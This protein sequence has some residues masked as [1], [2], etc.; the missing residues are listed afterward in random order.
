MLKEDKKDDKEVILSSMDVEALYPNINIEITAKEVGKE[1][2]ETML[3]YQNVDYRMAGILIASNMSQEGL[4]KEKLSEIV[5]RRKSNQGVRPGA[6]TE[7]LKRKRRYD[8]E[9]EEVE[10]SKWRM[11]KKYPHGSIWAFC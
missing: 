9:G 7:E 11:A 8:E 3:E 5:P 10:V 4:Y 2:E 1:A 6:T